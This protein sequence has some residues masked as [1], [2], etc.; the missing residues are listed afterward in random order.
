[1]RQ[2]QVGEL[3]AHVIA[4]PITSEIL[5]TLGRFSPYLPETVDPVDMLEKYLCRFLVPPPRTREAYAREIIVCRRS[6]PSVAL[7]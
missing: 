7:K 2:G 3:F 5:R 6:C 4:L 1:M